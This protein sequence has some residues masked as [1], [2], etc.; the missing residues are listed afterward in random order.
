MT[1]HALRKLFKRP[2]SRTKKTI[3][4]SLKDRYRVSAKAITRIASSALRLGHIKITEDQRRADTLNIDT[5]DED[6][7]DLSMAEDVDRNAIQQNVE[8]RSDDEDDD[9]EEITEQLSDYPDASF[10]PKS[11]YV[12]TLG[13]PTSCISCTQSTLIYN[14]DIIFFYVTSLI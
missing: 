5:D 9:F 3:V 10:I 1:A 11:L 13:W 12:H 7:E 2:K 8:I 4:P 6:E 14:T